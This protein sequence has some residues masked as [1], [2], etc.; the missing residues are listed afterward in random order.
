MPEPT[1]ARTLVFVD[2]AQVAACTGPAASTEWQDPAAVQEGA[3]VA[4]EDGRIAAVAPRDELLARYPDA[5]RVDCAGGVLT[6]GLVD[7]HTHAVF[8]RWRADEYVLRCTGVPYMEIARRGGGINASVRD[9]RA[10]SEDELVEMALPRLREMLLNGTTTAEVKSGYGLSTADELKTLRAV[11]RLAE[12]Q[13]VELVP[14]FLGAHEFPPEHRD[15]RDAYVD[16]LVEEMIPAVAEAGL[17]RFC[18][19]FMEPGVFDRAQTERI[20]RAGLDHGLRPKLHADELEGSGGAELA[21]ELGAASADHL[22]DV[23]EAGIRALAVS[24]TVATLLPA[25]L[26]FLGRPKFAPARALLEAGATVALATDFNP[27]SSPTPSLPFVMT[28]ACSRM[29]MSPAEALRAA[30]AGGAAALEIADGRG[31]LAPGAPA[32]LALWRVQSVA[33]IPYRLAAP[34]CAGVWK[35]GRRVV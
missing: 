22:G 25:T 13:P 3:A 20:L 34:V 11:R 14:T 9:L 16:L 2:A 10:R 31:T 30:T 4:V 29:G 5:E 26:F 6:P 18:D 28:A 7:S 27:G 17:A 35:R 24:G 15:R 19:V 8:G 21:V 12:M 23:S 32:D 33:E 1:P